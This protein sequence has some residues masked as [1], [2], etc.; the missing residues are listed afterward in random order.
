M[1]TPAPRTKW[2]VEI[3]KQIFILLIGG[4]LAHALLDGV[5]IIAGLGHYAL[6]NGNDDIFADSIKI[7]LAER[8][9]SFPLLTDPKVLE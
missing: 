7:S 4:L 1:I 8:T 3:N 5:T 2:P 9:V 6:F